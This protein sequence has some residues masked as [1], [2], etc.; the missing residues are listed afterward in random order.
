M[1]EEVRRNFGKMTLNEKRL[2]KMDLAVNTSF[3]LKSNMFFL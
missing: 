3:V 1:A 2:N